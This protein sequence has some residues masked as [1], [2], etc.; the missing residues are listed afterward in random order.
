MSNILKRLSRILD[1]PGGRQGLEGVPSRPRALVLNH[2]AVP[3]GAPGGTRHVEL[4]QRL[5]AWDST[6]I[7]SNFSS[8][9]GTRVRGSDQLKTVPVVPYTSNGVGRILNWGSYA[10][11]GTLRGLL[12]GPADIVY[13]ST[14]HLLTPLS[15]WLLSRIKGAAF[16]VEIRDLWP[17]VLLDMGVLS[18]T[19]PMFR[20][21]TAV[22]EFIYSQA[23]AIIVMAEGSR[24]EL[25]R[26]G[27]GEKDIY[28]IPNGA[29]PEDFVSAMPRDVLREKYGMRRLTG[30]YVGAHGPANGLDL[31]LKAADEA[32][33]VDIVLVGGGPEKA[34]LQQWARD[35]NLQNVRFLDAVPKTEVPDILAAADFGLHVLADVELFRTSVSPNKVFDYMAVGLPVLSN[36]PGLVADLLMSAEAGL[37]VGPCELGAGLRDMAS[38]SEA[39]RQQLGEN[40]RL[41]LSQNQSRTIMAQRLASAL[42]TTRSQSLN[43]SR[44]RV[45]RRG[46]AEH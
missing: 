10:V 26:R 30:V 25:T 28:Y 37:A 12:C 38:Q 23:D 3:P 5:T 11:T 16:V 20:A 46:P 34:R 19:S 29:D 43:A 6:I 9:T 27:F 40:G 4:F 17:K 44:I 24:T 7:A 13:G 1:G 2:F 32:S 31:L 33:N 22:E 39:S 14:P 18:E 21:L 35:Q 15:A 42:E 45:R 36:S 41:W 8:Q